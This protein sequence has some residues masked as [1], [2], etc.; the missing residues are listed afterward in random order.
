MIETRLETKL[1]TKTW[2]KEKWGITNIEDTEMKK[3]QRTTREHVSGEAR[4]KKARTQRKK[5]EQRKQDHTTQRRAKEQQA[6]RNKK[7]HSDSGAGNCIQ[8]E[9]KQKK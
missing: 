6:Q 4:G 1:E 2:K 9:N 5:K 3:W 8:P 7:Q